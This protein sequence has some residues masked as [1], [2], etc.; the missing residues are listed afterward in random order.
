[1][2]T[3]PSPSLLCCRIPV[4]TARS[5]CHSDPLG[6]SWQVSPECRQDPCRAPCPCSAARWEQQ[7]L[8]GLEMC[9]SVNESSVG[10]PH[11]AAQNITP[12]AQLSGACFC[13]SF[14]GDGCRESF[15][16]QWGRAVHST[17]LLWTLSEN[18]G[19]GFIWSTKHSGKGLSQSSA[20]RGV[21]GRDWQGWEA[22]IQL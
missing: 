12:P 14:L 2:Q 5:L 19:Q 1:M 10:A 7:P 18:D 16:R 13:F 3:L 21:W 4:A 11:E 9:I 22:V 15:P 20:G 8:A 6:S 17:N